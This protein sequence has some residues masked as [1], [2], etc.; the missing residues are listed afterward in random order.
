MLREIKNYTASIKKL[1]NNKIINKNFINFY[2][3]ILYLKKKK[4][5]I[6]S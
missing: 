4:L 5:S 3:F 6:I 2:Y 1:L